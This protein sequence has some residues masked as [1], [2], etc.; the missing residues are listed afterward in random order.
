MLP[1]ILYNLIAKFLE[2]SASN[3]EPVIHRFLLFLYDDVKEMPLSRT[4]FL[5]PGFAEHRC[6]A[7]SII[8]FL[9]KLSEILF[10]ALVLNVWK[11]ATHITQKSAQFDPEMSIY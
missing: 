9:K 3:V 11:L 7:K 6:F 5:N 4:V 8:R 2:K 10:A 1:R